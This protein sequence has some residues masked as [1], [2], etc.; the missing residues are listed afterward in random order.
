MTSGSYFI[1]DKENGA[2][3]A[4]GDRDFVLLNVSRFMN[5]ISSNGLCHSERLKL[6]EV[7]TSTGVYK[8]DDPEVIEK[9]VNLR[10]YLIW[11]ITQ[12]NVKD[13]MSEFCKDALAA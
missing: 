11:H 2:V 10:G 4:R 7:V 9:V 5:S 3:I 13:L 12:P 6:N 8:I 1:V